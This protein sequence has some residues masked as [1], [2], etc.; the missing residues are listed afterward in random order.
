MADIVLDTNLLSE[1]IKQF[2]NNTETK[3]HFRFVSNSLIGRELAK[4]MN[5][6]VE[7]YT[8][9]IDAR[10]PG[11]IIASAFGFVEIA[12]KFEEISSGHYNIEQFAAFVE[13]PPIWF[14]I[15]SVDSSLFPHLKL[16]PKRVS[17]NNV[18]KPIEWADAIHVATAMSRDEPW[19]LAST[20][21]RIKAIPLLL[22]KVK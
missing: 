9:D 17:V 13:Q 11:L 6:I 22:T 20:D 12:R 10:C 18:S 15:S 21:T 3:I 8:S 7:W 14:R 1:V 16:I 5:T 2:F 4:E 19:L